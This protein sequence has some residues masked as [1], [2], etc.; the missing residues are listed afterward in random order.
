MKTAAKIFLYISLALVA[1]WILPWAW[2]IVTLKSYSTPFTLYSCVIHDFTS[3]DRTDNNELTFIDRNGNVH[4]D[5]VQPL[6]YGRVLNNK[7]AL[8]DTIMGRPVTL[9]LIDSMNVTFSAKP[10]D[11]NKKI[12]PV[13]LLMESVP[14]RMELQDPVEA[15]VLRKDGIVLYDITDNSLESEKT[16]EF[17]GAL[18]SQGF[19][20]PVVSYSGNASHHKL[21]DEGYL[22]TDSAGNLFQLKQ[23]DGKP[24]ARRFTQADGID[25][26]YVNITEL[27]SKATLGWFTDASNNMYF[28]RPDGEVFSTA[29]KYNPAVESLLGVGDLFYY[30]IKVSDDDG[31]HFYA[32]DANDFSLVDTMDRPYDFEEEFNLC[33]YLFPCRMYFTSSKEEWVRPH[34]TDFSWIGLIVDLAAIGLVV[35]LRRRRKQ[36]R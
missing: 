12:T 35:F 8:P 5:E 27:S 19:V 25:V 6:F 26:K 15:F 14:V 30:T 28:L 32:L 24:F 21:Y 36:A 1:I 22:L 13:C 9:A 23:I 4:S 16:E 31:E 2:R 17:S 20:F 29:V 33:K 10:K 3:L 34:F 18:A 7:G 11:F